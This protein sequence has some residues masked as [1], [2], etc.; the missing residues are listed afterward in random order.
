MSVGL[1]IDTKTWHLPK[2]VLT[3]CSP[4]FAA[5]LNSGFSEGIS[6]SVNLPEEN[7]AAF[8]IW[9]I[10]IHIGLLSR[11]S[12][13][14]KT[15]EASAEELDCEDYIAAEVLM[16]AWGLGDK[17]VCPAF[18]DNMMC[19]LVKVIYRVPF[20]TDFLLLAYDVSSAKSK[21]RRFAV[22][23]YRW[24]V[25]CGYS[26]GSIDEWIAVAEAVPDFWKDHMRSSDLMLVE[27]FDTPFLQRVR[28][29]QNSEF[30][31][32]FWFEV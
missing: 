8:E 22:E 30:K 12:L 16:K 14:L 2:K 19:H 31:M 20:T 23:Q 25:E 10:W 21:L 3:H 5:A 6:K 15:T 7:P 26:S 28:Y 18:Q 11:Q 9:I 17:L 4:F 1:G 13:P 27:E 32:E 29:Y 24:E